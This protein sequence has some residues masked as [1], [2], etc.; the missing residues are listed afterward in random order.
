MKVTDSY[1]AASD[2]FGRSVSISGDYA[3]ARII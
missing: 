3:T 2:Y 1:G